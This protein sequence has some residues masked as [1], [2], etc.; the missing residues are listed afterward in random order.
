MPTVSVPARC[1]VAVICGEHLVSQVYPASVPVEVFL[2]NIVELLNDDLKRRGAPALDSGIAYELQRANGTR[3]DATKTLDE[4]G[5]EDGDT[6][7]LV[8][9]ERGES[10]EPQ[11][12]SLS[13]GLARVG[14]KLFAPVTAQT[15]VTASLVI[16][17]MVALTVLGLTIRTRLHT[18]SWVTA[19]APL[20]LGAALAFGGFSV[21][22]GW[23]DR[24]QLS[25]GLAWLSVPL[26][27]AGF[28][29]ATPGDL[30]AAH[31]FITALTVAVLACALAA[32]TGRY[33]SIAATVVTLCAIGGVLGAVRMWQPVPGQRLGM[34]TLIGL[35][36]LVT[37]GPTIALWVARIRPPH[38][39]S[40]T[41][42]DVFRRSDGMP[43]D[44]VAPVEDESEDEP[45]PDATPR[46][47]VIATAARRANHVLTGICVAAAIALPVAVWA[48]LIPGQPKATPA[49]VLSGLFVVIFISRGRAFAD[50]RQ[51]VALVCG[52]AAAACSGV[53]RYVLAGSGESVA[54]LLWGSLVLTVFGAAGLAAALLVPVTRFTPLVRM[55]AEWLELAAIVAALPMAAWIGGLFTWVRM[56]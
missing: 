52:A 39:G 7:V 47:E 14:K 38:F 21:W 36:L 37:T 9:A 18:D 25:T 1:A 53:A 12:E 6:L 44:A 55:V 51:A 17:G 46:G 3:L 54:P 31:V 35:F 20:A 5:I 22:R 27:A 42:R 24:W 32:V 50:R 23:R 10:F 16:L 4:L 2:D 26:L 33:I 49:A 56:R 41:G 30:G 19:S 43:V 45:N 8:P 13:T 40:I 11:Y 15:A 29:A 48:T 34:C 28:A